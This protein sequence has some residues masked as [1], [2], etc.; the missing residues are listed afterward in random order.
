MPAFN[1]CANF[2]LF[3]DDTPFPPNF[4]LAA[5]DFDQLGGPQWFVN[6]TGA[7]RGLQ[8]PPQGMEITIP[9]PVRTVRFRIGTFNGP[10]DI[11]ALD[12][13]GTTVKTKTIPALNSYVT[14]SIHAPEISSV[15]LTNGGSE[16]ILVRI[17]EA[18][19]TP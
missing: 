11:A 16:G 3:A 13:A 5:F 7:E 19:T 1:L 8:F 10:V 9:V 2:S 17:C 4:T 12:S 18:I 14:T 15:V 6:I